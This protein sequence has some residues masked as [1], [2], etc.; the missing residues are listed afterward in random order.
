[1]FLRKIKKKQDKQTKNLN[2][3]KNVPKLQDLFAPDG[4]EEHKDFLHTGPS[5]YSRVYVLAIYPREINIGWL[6]RIYSLGDV[7][8]SIHVDPVPNRAVVVDLTRKVSSAQAQYMVYEKKGNILYLPELE[9]VIRDLEAT[10]SNIQTNRDKLFYVLVTITLNARSLDE[11][12][13]KSDN[14]E[15][16]LAASSTQ[17]RTLMFRQLDGLKNGLPINTPTIPDYWRNMT[18]GGVAAMMPVAN[19]DLSH[20]SG[21]FLGYN[22]HSGAPMFLDSFIGP[23]HLNNQHIAV[24]GGSGS[25]KSVLLKV[26]TI[27]RS[28]AQGV[29]VV[30]LDPEGECSR[31]VEGLLG[32]VVVKI[33]SNT[34]SGINPFDVEPDIDDNGN[35]ISINL[36]DK[37]NEIRALVNSIIFN[38]SA[39]HLTPVETAV[40][41]D[42]IREVYTDKEITSDPNSIYRSASGELKEGAF[43]VGQVKK[44]MPTLT[45]L[46]EVLKTKTHA[47][48]LCILLAPFLRGG[49][50]GMFD[51]Q[52]TVDL[53]S[54]VISLDLSAIKDEFTRFYA[55]YVLL[56]WSWQKFAQGVLGV[57]KRIVL[58]EA[59][60]FMKYQDSADFLENLSKRGRKYRTSLVVASQQIEDFLDKK[61]GRAVIGNC[62]TFI[63]LR[64]NA[65]L[66]DHVVETFRLS[67]GCREYLQSFAPGEAI[68]SIGGNLTA[69]KIT[70]TAFEMPWVQTVRDW[71]EGG[72]SGV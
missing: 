68:I 31:L 9:Q 54:H 18:T 26:V 41:E 62:E 24:F 13:A 6:D 44:D 27:L 19:S 59:W 32:G 67:G 71:K 61:E 40:L 16:I 15:D 5:R 21:V 29:R 7:D 10:R 66:V 70:P 28:V 20:P 22:Y 39:R 55:M 72:A 57:D 63:L 8:I 56:G 36:N 47:E 69:V 25:G 51:C 50:L 58:D 45:D 11:L 53:K 35:I 38:R 64:Q 1:M 60:F 42:S 12:N 43:A 2:L 4:L 49:T 34:P 46:V 52:T 33:N 30:A 37:I 14:M 48:E 23:P 17:I 65:A 3:E